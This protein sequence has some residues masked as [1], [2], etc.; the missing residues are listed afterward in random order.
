M[1]AIAVQ[2]AR[3]LSRRGI[4]TSIIVPG[5]FTS[6][7]NHFAN[8]SRPADAGRAAKYEAGPRITAL[9]SR[10]RRHLRP[11]SARCRRRR[12]RRG[13][14]ECCRRPVRKATVSRSRRS[15]AG[16]RRCRLRSAR[17]HSRR[18]AAPGRP[19]RPS[20]AENAG[21]SIPPSRPGGPVAGCL[22]YLA[23]RMTASGPHRVPVAARCA[24]ATLFGKV[25]NLYFQPSRLHIVI[26][27]FSG[28]ACLVAQ[29]G[30]RRAFGRCDHEVVAICD[31]GAASVRN[32][33]SRGL[34]RRMAC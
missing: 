3:E 22:P 9:A 26:Q 27:R 6:G 28:V 5:A 15:H 7:T 13:D 18:D 2:Y 19:E 17:S 23:F 10:S 33:R 30:L 14:R 12:R 1:D 24:R 31:S 21:L 32:G 8:A 25:D 16:W 29:S 20:K 34:G 4:E 11:S